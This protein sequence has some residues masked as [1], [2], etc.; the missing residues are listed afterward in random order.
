[1][2]KKDKNAHWKEYMDCIQSCILD[3]DGTILVIFQ[4]TLSN[5]DVHAVPTQKM[6]KKTDNMQVVVKL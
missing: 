4:E 1:L 5:K 3:F 2:K 6:T